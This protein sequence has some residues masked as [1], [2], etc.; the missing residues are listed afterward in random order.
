MSIY[1]NQTNIAPGTPFSTGGGGSNF[2]SISVSSIS[3]VY[4]ISGKLF[5]TQS[6]TYWNPIRFDMRPDEA[7]KGGSIELILNWDAIDTGANVACILGTNGSTAYLTSAWLGQ[8]GAPLT[9]ASVNLSLKGDNE[10]FLNCDADTGTM[11]AGVPFI[12]PT[13]NFSSITDPTKQY[14]ADVTALFST[15]ASLYPSCFV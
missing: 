4:D 6:N 10:T 9:I 13:N 14:T 2:N 12:S 3:G 1:F 15:L 8:A 5:T 11:T 7:V